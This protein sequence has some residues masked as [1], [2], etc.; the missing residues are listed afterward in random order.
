MEKYASLYRIKSEFFPSLMNDIYNGTVPIPKDLTDKKYFEIVS[1]SSK[2]ELKAFKNKKDMADAIIASLPSEGS[3]KTKDKAFT[4][5]ELWGWLALALNKVVY[6]D[7]QGKFNAA[8][9][10][11]YYF[12]PTD[13]D[14][15]R[16]NYRHL[17][18]TPVFVRYRFGDNAVHLL[19]SKI[20]ESGEL[21]EQLLS[22]QELW[23]NHLMELGKLLY[24]DEKK[25]QLKKH[26]AG[27]DRPGTSRRLAAYLNQISVTFDTEV[28]GAKKLLSILPS[29][30]DDF[31]PNKSKIKK[32]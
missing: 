25:Q 8:K 30:F 13:L 1:G 27:K 20:Y 5:K 14:D 32:A 28:L 21:V 4:D 2:F 26:A 10:N 7:K 23:Q 18:R 12:V 11:L 6:S 16:A 31:K 17:I 9:N 15:Y 19:D 29:E 3:E 22:R 24:Y